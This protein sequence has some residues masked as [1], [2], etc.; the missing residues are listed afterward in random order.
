MHTV[1]IKGTSKN[2][3]VGKVVCLAR[4]YSDHIKEL[5]NE[6]P[7][8]PVLFIKPASS[9]IGHRE[10]VVIPR[11]SKD[12]HHEVELAVL[13]GKF[14]KNIPEAD[15]MNHVAG[16]GIAIDMTLRDVQ[17]ELKQ[18]GL[19]WEIAKGFDTACP[20]S[21]FIPAEEVSDPHN[22]RIT[23]R[24]NDHVRQDGSTGQMMRR[25]PAIIAAVSEVFTLEEGDII[26][27][28]TPAGVGP[29]KSGDLMLAEIEQLGHLEVKVQ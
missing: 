22:L 8:K 21:S 29:V 9:I 15:A 7:D 5:G 26:L 18:K 27:T 11:F 17:S 4:N 3:I 20:L 1:R 10:S 2:L 13:I 28:G 14:G 19:P 23:L 16:Y 12:C 6:T 24:V 25:I